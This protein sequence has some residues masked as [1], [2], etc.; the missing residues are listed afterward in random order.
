MSDNIRLAVVIVVLIAIAIIVFGLMRRGWRGRQERQIEIDEPPPLPPLA[1]RGAE[2]AGPFDAYYVSSTSAHD[3]LDRIA[4]HQLGERSR[5]VVTVSMGG[6]AIERHG[7]RDVWISREDLLA[8]SRETGMAGK[9]V[10]RTGIVVLRWDLGE[11]AVATGIHLPRASDRDDVE[12]A[13]ASLFTDST[14][15]DTPPTTTDSSEA[16]SGSTADGVTPTTSIPPTS[17]PNSDDPNDGTTSG[18]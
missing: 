11:T 10:P 12:G 18:A 3:W 1:A 5:A 4:V 2:I 14:N 15:G 7:A 16:K 8:V 17:T 13:V 9:F 6:V